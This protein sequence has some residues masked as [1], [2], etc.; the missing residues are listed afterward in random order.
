MVTLAA[1]MFAG[2]QAA[3]AAVGVGHTYDPPEERVPPVVVP[4]PPPPIPIVV[5]PRPAPWIP[6]FNLPPPPTELPDATRDLIKAA[7]QAGDDAT[8]TA[9]FKLARTTNP[10]AK[11]Q[12][13][14]LE[15]DIAAQR[16]EKLAREARERAD[17]LK[18]ASFIDYWKGEVELGG[19]R[20]T[21]NSNILTIY[22]AVSADREGLKWTHSLKARVDYQRSN[23]ETKADRYRLAWQP[24]YK[25]NE[26]VF[27]YGLSQYER[28][29]FLGYASRY[30]ASS[31][32]GFTLI[33]NPDAKLNVQGG[34]ALRYTDAIGSPNETSAA[35]RASMSLRWKI[36]PTLNLSQDA[37]LYLER[38]DTNAQSTTSLDTRL[39]GQLKARFSYDILYEDRDLTGKEPLDTVSRATLVYSF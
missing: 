38:G 8:V 27:I 5:S 16:A 19:S 12:I 37:A 15:A 32:V 1:I 17:R 7:Y 20:S 24:S 28:D 13:D 33:S 4:P 21:G 25:I 18:A 31:G 23:G 35:A 22:G 36:T 29:R 39:I 11:A 9:L 2:A 14:A 10:Q 34:P 26:K 6:F 30:T 3:G